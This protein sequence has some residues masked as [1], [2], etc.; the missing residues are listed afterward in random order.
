MEREPLEAR[1]ERPRQRA[2]SMLTQLG[3]KRWR[4]TLPVISCA[5]LGCTR[6]SRAFQVLI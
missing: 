1:S 5:H 3:E 2:L 6:S 4:S